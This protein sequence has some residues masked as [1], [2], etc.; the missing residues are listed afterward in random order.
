M[1]LRAC[2]A[3]AVVL[4]SAVSADAQPLSPRNANYTIDVTLDTRARTLSGRETLVWTNITMPS[5]DELQFHLY[6]NAWRNDESTWMREHTLTSWWQRSI[7]AARRR[8]CRHRHLEPR[9]HGGAVAP[10]D[11]TKQMRFI[12]PDD[13]NDERPHGDGRCPAGADRPGRD[14]HDRHRIYREDPAPVRA[15]RRRRQLLLHRAMVSRRSACSMRPAPGTAISFMSARS[16][17][18]T[19]A[20]TT[21]A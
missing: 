16:S 14:T 9:D 11:L 17:F 6:Y 10:V 13:G 21:C 12:A 1:I 19:S 7:D 5:T 4:T 20:C 15:H 18:P 3:M 8:S 2:L